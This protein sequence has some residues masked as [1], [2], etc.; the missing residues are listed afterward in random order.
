MLNEL[1]EEYPLIVDAPSKS[2]IAI[3]FWFVIWA[4]WMCWA[5]VRLL[6]F[7]PA[8]TRHRLSTPT[9]SSV[10]DPRFF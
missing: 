8:H 3:Y 4:S 5:I 6:M 10:I 7:K 9:A 2:P 1:T